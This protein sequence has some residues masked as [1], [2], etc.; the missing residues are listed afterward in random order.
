[1]RR[2]GAERRAR[3]LLRW[4]PKEWRLRYG[5]EFTQLLTDDIGRGRGTARS[6]W[7]EAALR[8]RSHNGS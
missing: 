4:Y 7:H 8:L 3:R 6:T 1:M 2:A 5:E